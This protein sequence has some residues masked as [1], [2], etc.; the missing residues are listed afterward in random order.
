[1]KSGDMKTHTG[2]YSCNHRR[3]KSS[4]S[5]CFLLN[6]SLVL[7]LAPLVVFRWKHGAHTDPASIHVWNDLWERC[8]L[9]SLS[10]CCCKRWSCLGKPSDDS[11]WQIDSFLVLI[12]TFSL[13]ACVLQTLWKDPQKNTEENGKK[14]TDWVHNIHRIQNIHK[15]GG[16]TQ[17]AQSRRRVSLNG[18]DVALMHAW[19]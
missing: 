11:C 12:S 8:G 10:C 18:T 3:M 13:C 17:T 2:N 16:Q 19:A 7:W 14:R 5:V 15:S 6:T 9:Q 4:R 1:M